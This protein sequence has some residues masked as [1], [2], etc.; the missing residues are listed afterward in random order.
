MRQVLRK[1]G[2]Q[3]PG[4]NGAGWIN[5]SIFTE[6]LL[7]Q[8]LCWAL[9]HTSET[10]VAQPLGRRITRQLQHWVVGVVMEPH[11]VVGVVIGF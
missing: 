7:C 8:A 1:E 10:Y 3:G 6:Y 9:E 4:G 5:S 2:G 11:W